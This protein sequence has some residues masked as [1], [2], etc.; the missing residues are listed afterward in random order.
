MPVL[1]KSDIKEPMLPK[2]TVTVPELGGDVVV[3]GLLLR[4]RLALFAKKEVDFGDFSKTLA[5]TVIDANGEP[6]F[7]QDGWENFGAAN[8]AAA[9]NLFEVASRLSGL[10]AKVAEKN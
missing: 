3:R 1:N 5:V 8:F 9:M 10:N 6:I 4:D 7:D 2:E